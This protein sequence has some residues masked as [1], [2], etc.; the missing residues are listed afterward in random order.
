MQRRRVGH[1]DAHLALRRPLAVTLGAGFVEAGAVQPGVDGRHLDAEGVEL[2]LHRAGDR[3]DRVLGGRVGAQERD[4]HQPGL[5]RHP[6]RPCRACASSWR[7]SARCARSRWA[8]TLI[9]N[10]RRTGRAGCR[11]A[12][13]PLARRRSGSGCRPRARPR[14]RGPI[15]SSRSS[16]I[17]SSFA[18]SSA[19]RSRSDVTCCQV[20]P[21]A[22]TSNRE[23]ASSRAT[24]APNPLVAP[25]MR[26]LCACHPRSR[27]CGDPRSSEPAR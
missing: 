14:A 9:S 12:A 15:G 22:V 8:S 17:T 1:R 25:V 24:P 21:A 5:R 10:E 26:T 3:L 7:G 27:P 11:R 18:F 23:R 20:C 4:A 2:G 13:R 6:D 16:L 19:A